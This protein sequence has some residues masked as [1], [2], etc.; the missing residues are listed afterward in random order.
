MGALAWTLHQ[1]SG[2]KA[3]VWGLWLWA[4]MP[5][6]VWHERL[7]LQDP[8][9]TAALA[10]AV[11]L[12]TMGSRW[13]SPVGG[14]IYLG[15]GIMFGLA[16]LLKISAIFATPWL[17]LWHAALQRESG[18]TF[19]D[20]R[21]A[22]LVAGAVAPIMLLGTQLT[23]LGIRLGTYHAIPNFGDVEASTAL[24]QR[25][26]VWTGWYLGY[27]GWPLLLLLT[28]ALILTV[29]A[30]SPRLLLWGI[31]AGWIF[32][33]VISSALYNN[34]FARYALPDHLPLLLFLSLALGSPTD[35]EWVRLSSG[36][37]IAA[38]VRWF[39][40]S[41][42]IVVEPR[43]SAVPASEINQYLTGQ[44]SGRGTGELRR[45]LSDFADSSQTPC[46][47]LTHRFHRPGCYGLMLS[48]LADPRIVV[49]PSMVESPEEL[50]VATG[51]LTQIANDRKVS[52][53]LLYE[54]RRQRNPWPSGPDSTTQLILSIDR[55]EGEPFCL[56]RINR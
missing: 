11:A 41:W 54:D 56:Y 16:F 3:A 5:I 29:R 37:T 18:R 46:I 34:V 51:Q 38:L 39:A 52:F 49:V 15:A 43:Q 30:N 12:V 2:R 32:S 45:F 13:R 9:V 42:Q 40:V 20:R 55:G 10:G 48:A 17:I 21:L 4:I 24:V 35:R 28:L 47:V 23:R 6:A 1:V 8:F 50:A 27:G 25:I 7:A 14:M 19:L 44:W 33:L 31:F 22:L 26:E 36:I 53:F